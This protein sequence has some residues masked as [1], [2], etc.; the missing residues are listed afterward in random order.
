MSQASVN[1]RVV[2]PTD[3]SILSRI[4]LLTGAAGSSAE[5]LHA[6]PDLLGLIFTS[7]YIQLETT[8]GFVLTD[9][10]LPLTHAEGQQNRV[11]GYILGTTDSKKF[12]QIA[13]RE[14]WPTLRQKYPKSELIT[15]SGRPPPSISFI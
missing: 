15:R 12:E 9:A 11:V 7:P 10:D 8:F 2:R 3:S 6:I 5:S 13:E 14:W 4:C 1:I